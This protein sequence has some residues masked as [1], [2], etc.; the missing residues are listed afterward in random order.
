MNEK[1]ITD[2]EKIDAILENFHLNLAE[3]SRILGVKIDDIYSVYYEKVK[4]LSPLLMRKIV[5][6]YPAI[7]PYW[8]LTGEGDM[9]ISDNINGNSNVIQHHNGKA[10]VENSANID[11]LVELASSQQRTIEKLV[12]LIKE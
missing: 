2:K 6:Q 12:N 8:L 9:T 5:K 11:K 4:G 3:F 1:K 10:L 7:S